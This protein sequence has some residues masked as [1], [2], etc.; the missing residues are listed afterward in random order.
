MP[1]GILTA[2]GL[3]LSSLW[4]PEPHRGRPCSV[5]SIFYITSRKSDK[6]VTFNTG[7]TETAELE[8][9]ASALLCRGH[10]PDVVPRIWFNIS[11]FPRST[12]WSLLC[13][14]R[15]SGFIWRSACGRHVMTQCVWVQVAPIFLLVC[16]HS[17]LLSLFCPGNKEGIQ[18]NEL[19]PKRVSSARAEQ[20]THRRVSLRV[21]GACDQ[22]VIDFHWKPDPSSWVISS[23]LERTEVF[24]SQIRS[25]AGWLKIAECVQWSGCNSHVYS[26]WWLTVS[27][28]ELFS[29]TA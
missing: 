21:C 1:K 3:C 28:H 11:S 4:T 15:S 7:C 10:G 24:D 27:E 9:S 26:S 19:N 17:S 6:S 14:W 29:H 22:R 2:A 13:L 16:H 5:P 20:P 8:T 12:N 25:V 23:V 18:Q